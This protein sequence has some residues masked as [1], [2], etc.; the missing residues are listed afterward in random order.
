MP[1]EAVRPVLTTAWVSLTDD[2]L[3]LLLA[4]ATWLLQGRRALPTRSEWQA[5]APSVTLLVASVAAALLAPAFGDVSLRSVWRLVA[6][7]FVLLLIRRVTREPRGIVGVQWALAIGAAGSAVLGLGEASGWSGFEPAL[8][9][10]KVAPTRVGA[11]LRVSASFQY[12]TIASMYFEMVAPLAVVLAAT[13]TRRR[14]R[15]LGLAIAGLC[16]ANVVLSLTRAGVLTLAVV[17]A[18]LLGYA[19]RRQGRRLLWPTLAAF[20][21]LIG[22]V[23]MLALRDPV[24]D[25]RLV[26]E[27]DADWYAATYFGPAALNSAPDQSM[28][29]GLDVRNEGSLVWSASPNPGQHP[30]ALGY[31]WLTADA[32]GVLDV[33]PGEVPLP[34]DVKPGETIHL[35]ALVEASHLPPGTYRLDWGMLQRDVVQFYERGSVDAESLVSLGRPANG[36]VRPMPAISP[37]DD[38]QAPW[39]VG[40]IQ[41]WR[42]AL[43]LIQARPWLGVGPDN[44]RH[45]YGAQLGLDAWDERVQA[46]NLYLELLAD[47]GVLGLAAFVWVIVP[48][49]AGARRGLRAPIPTPPTFWLLG[50]CL[51]ALAFLVHGML[52]SFLA[53]T[54]TALLFWM[55]LAMIL[56]LRRMAIA[57]PPQKPHVSGR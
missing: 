4:A 18:A 34:H 15:F 41:L 36:E 44:F 13:A 26:S 2:K 33:P 30:F 31:R 10:F 38:G 52:D 45:L 35:E 50:C 56:N 11:D 20:G 32:S 53:F 12:A 5:L 21:V 42:A 24:F 49:L 9:L 37:R 28:Q 51:A 57:D 7:A 22:G 16:T 27:S 39:V 48:P 43:G 54:P 8:K 6:A 1:F 23:A 29:I 46:N 14:L 19:L 25:M 55:L 17:Y 40:R 47:T 3:V